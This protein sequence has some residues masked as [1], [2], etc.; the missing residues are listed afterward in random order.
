MLKSMSIKFVLLINFTFK[1]RKM[2]KSQ[3]LYPSPHYVIPVHYIL[4]HSNRHTF[5]FAVKVAIY[6]NMCYLIFIYK[7]KFIIINC[8]LM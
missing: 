7:F 3:F 2:G 8:K 5:N 6:Q 1:A 4:V